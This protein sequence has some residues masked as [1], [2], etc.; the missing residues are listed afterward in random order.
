MLHNQRHASGAGPLGSRMV[1]NA[2][3]VRSTST[4]DNAAPANTSGPQ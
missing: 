2:L 3:M 4:I 1:A